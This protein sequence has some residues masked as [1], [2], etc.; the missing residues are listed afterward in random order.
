M[1]RTRLTLAALLAAILFAPLAL[2]ADTPAD[3][4]GRVIWSTAAAANTDIFSAESR[5]EDSTPS[6][7]YRLTIALVSTNSVVNVAMT[8]GS[9]PSTV[10]FDLND[11]T[12]LTAGRLYTFTFG[13]E[14]AD[15]SR[16][17]ITYNVQCETA[18][19]VGYAS[20]QEVRIP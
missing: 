15:S 2:L 19:T 9:S 16:N 14:R 6:V 4:P 18:T 5:P 20:L 3:N 17:A 13:G 8:G 1:T 10:G 7:A 12:A 11:G